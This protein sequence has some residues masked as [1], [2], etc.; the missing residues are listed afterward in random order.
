MNAT[1]LALTKYSPEQKLHQI[2]VGRDLCRGGKTPL[3]SRVSHYHRLDLRY[4]QQALFAQA[5]V[6]ST[7]R[8]QLLV[9]AALDDATVI[10]YQNLIGVHNGR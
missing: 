4:L 6:F 1:P 2:L 10:E 3:I 9:G 5:R 8:Q 7:E